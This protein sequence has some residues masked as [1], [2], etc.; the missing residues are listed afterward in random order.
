MNMILFICVKLKTKLTQ[1]IDSE[2]RDCL[3][4][5]VKI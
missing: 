3:Q 5:L 1:K 4:I 2:V